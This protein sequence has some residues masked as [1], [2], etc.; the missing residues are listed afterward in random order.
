MG[1]LMRKIS[2]RKTRRTIILVF[3]LVFLG[4]IPPGLQEETWAAAAPWDEPVV[5]KDLEVS[6]SVDQQMT[7][8]QLVDM[9]GSVT[10][11][12]AD[13]ITADPANMSYGGA[14][15]SGI[16]TITGDPDTT[17]EI[18]ITSVTAD[19][20]TLSSF[21][22]SEGNASPSLLATLDSA[23]ELVVILGA[24]LTLDA[25]QVVLGNGQSINFTITTIYN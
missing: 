3:V 23:G 9:D 10:L 18:T 6:M 25:A 5:R 4:S 7:F 14:P 13:T 20:F 15:Y 24:T 16:Y 22:T 12:L 21:V 8:G 11:G 17:V 19:G 1:L 2:T